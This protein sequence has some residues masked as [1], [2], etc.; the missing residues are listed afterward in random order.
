MSAN[1]HAITHEVAARL[2]RSSSRLDPKGSLYIYIYI[3]REARPCP[4]ARQHNAHTQT[5][6]RW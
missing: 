1:T 5:G 6:D 4:T 2:H 3:R